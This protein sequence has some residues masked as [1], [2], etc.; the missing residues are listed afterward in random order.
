[1]TPRDRRAV[2]IA[3][4]IV[5]AAVLGLRVGPWSVRSYR[6]LQEEVAARSAVLARMR[7]AIGEAEALGDSSEVVRQ[8]YLAL[9]PRILSGDTEAAALASLTG[10]LG[11][12]ADRSRTTLERA[13]ALPD[14]TQVG[15]IRRVTIRASFEGDTRG[16]TAALRAIDTNPIALST[17]AVRVVAPD[18]ASAGVAPEVLKGEILI[19][20]WY[21]ERGAR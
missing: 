5:A 14:S 7:D 9:A 18:P 13:D 4:A 19:S 11:A 2:T 16:L 10:H 1:M 15:G 21:S 20:A 3:G 6:A 12:V 17:G 8:A